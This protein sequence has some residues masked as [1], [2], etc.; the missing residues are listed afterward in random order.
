MRVLVHSD[1]AEQW[2]QA[3]ARRLSGAEVVTSAAPEAERRDADYLVA[4]KPDAGLLREQ[5][6]L[7]GIINLG[8]G[9]DALLNNPGLP[10]GVPIVKL[11]DAGMAGPIADYVRYGVLHFQRDFDRYGRQQA[12]AEWHEHAMV[13]KA[14][15]PVGVLGLGAIGAKVAA[16]LAA[17]GFPVHGWSRTPKSLEG[18]AC[19]HGEAGLE[20]L[21]GQVMSLVLL[22]PDTP[23]TQRLI[24]ARALA[25]LPAGASLIN[26][27]RGSLI[28]E[29]A[30]L[31][32]LGPGDA[33]GRLRGALLDAF[34]KEPLPA[35]SPFWTHPRV[36]VT[37]HMAGP[38]PL[39][40]ALDQVV[41]SLEAFEA[42]KPQATIDPDAGY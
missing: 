29:A 32:A 37:P 18:I 15:W 34:P 6:R 36:W 16:T 22:L 25:C 26:P 8:A 10:S 39:G 7:K 40:A 20:A 2:R 28:D 19:H 30:L 9:V 31:D 4:W 3:L 35:D 23:A 1:D 5:A 38:T 12:R 41:E 11:R 24:D 17:D 27:G 21:L 33:E 14:D 13:D 42:G